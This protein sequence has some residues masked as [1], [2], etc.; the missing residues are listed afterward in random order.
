MEKV[1]SQLS[2]EPVIYADR[3]LLEHREESSKLR[4]KV[5]GLREKIKHLETC[6][7]EYGKFEGSE[8][9]VSQVL[10]LAA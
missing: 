10:G 4:Q 1:N 3:F 7:N 6:L 9:N 2:I 8:Y 5:N